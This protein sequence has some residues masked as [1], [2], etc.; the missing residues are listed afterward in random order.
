MGKQIKNSTR[1]YRSVAIEYTDGTA[2]FV[3]HGNHGD[4]SYEIETSI[5]VAHEMGEK[6]NASVGR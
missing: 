4:E 3:F 2:K 1:Y 5:D 6:E